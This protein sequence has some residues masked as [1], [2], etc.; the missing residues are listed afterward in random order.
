M[1]NEEATIAQDNILLTHDEARIQADSYQ[2]LPHL[3]LE[4]RRKLEDTR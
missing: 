1:E 3:L 2:E 4:L